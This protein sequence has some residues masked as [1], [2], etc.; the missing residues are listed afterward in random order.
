M[1]TL[2]G[3]KV[4]QTSLKTGLR[5]RGGTWPEEEG[6]V[7]GALPWGEAGCRV[8]WVWSHLWVSD[9]GTE[10]DRLPRVLPRPNLSD[11][12]SAFL[13]VRALGL[14]QGPAPQVQAPV[15]AH[16]PDYR[17]AGCV[18]DWGHLL[19]LLTTDPSKRSETGSHCLSPSTNSPR[20]GYLKPL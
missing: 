8:F 4:S 2:S 16:L 14:C 10:Q 7:W 1:G 15:D 12:F 13:P 18:G 20:T 9:P 6:G 17:R 11:V 5:P 19:S 3:R